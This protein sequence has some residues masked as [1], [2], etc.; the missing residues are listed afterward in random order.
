[1]LSFLKNI[2]KKNYYVF[3]IVIASFITRMIYVFQ[4]TDYK[5]YLVSDMGG[6]WDRAIGRYNG[7]LFPL[8]Q[9]TGWGPFYHFYLTSI[10]KIL[11]FL[12]LF[13]HKLEIVIFLG[14]LFSSISI[15]FVYLISSYLLK[16]PHSILATLLY[17]FSYPLIYLNSLILTENLSI[18]IL[19]LAVFLLFT[20]HENKLIMFLTGAILA[21]A[22]A[23]RPALGLMFISFFIYILYYKKLDLGSIFRS[24]LF[25]CGF[26][27]IIFLTFVE[28]FYISKGELISLYGSSGT[29]FF[30]LQ[31]KHG[32]IESNYKGYYYV[33]SPPFTSSNHPNWPVF[34]TDH[35]L[36][37]QKYFYKLGYE[38]MKKNPNF[39][40]D[41]LISLRALFFNCLFPSFGSAANFGKLIDFAN[42]LI[43]FMTITLGLLYFLLKDK[44]LESKNVIFLISPILYTAIMSFFF[45]P[46]QRYLYPALFAIHILFFLVISYAKTYKQLYFKYARIALIVYLVYLFFR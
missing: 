30:L 33:G 40:L 7:D 32:S 37:D 29:T 45:P 19:I 18:P 3:I 25:A 4:Y 23:C 39:L 22:V 26:C 9:W 43:F 35:A 42:N 41:G 13:D 20:Y 17:A 38:C 27:I 46:E 15:I 2:P 24:V 28:I 14:I 5:G 16:E 1:M 36:H 11:S 8:S 6:Y 12:H 44:I 34:K 10:F 31:C 21:I